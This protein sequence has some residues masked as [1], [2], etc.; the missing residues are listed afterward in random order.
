MIYHAWVYW[1]ITMAY[2]YHAW[3]YWVITNALFVLIDGNIM[4]MFIMFE[5]ML[6]M[7][8]AIQIITERWF[9]QCK[10]HQYMVWL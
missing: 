6:L 5:M 3:V 10:V 7:H 2:D 8:G 1:V 9:T 4:H